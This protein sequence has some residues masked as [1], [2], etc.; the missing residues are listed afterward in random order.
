MKLNS[1]GVNKVSYFPTNNK[2]VTSDYIYVILK[3]L[4]SSLVTSKGLSSLA[5]GNRAR[6]FCRSLAF[7]LSPMRRVTLTANLRIPNLS[8]FQTPRNQFAPVDVS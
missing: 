2:M 3:E 8:Q 5:R 7:F 6:D 4:V 1:G